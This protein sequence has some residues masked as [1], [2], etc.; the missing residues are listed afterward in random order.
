MSFMAITA[1]DP[2]SV[3]F[4]L[5]KRTVNKHFVKDLTVGVVHAFV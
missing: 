5:H 2:G 1:G 3:H 4:A